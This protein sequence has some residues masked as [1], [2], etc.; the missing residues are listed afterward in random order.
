[1]IPLDI[2]NS[3]EQ[4]QFLTPTLGAVIAGVLALL[5]LIV[6]GFASGSEIAIFSLSPNDVSELEE[7]KSDADRK[8][9]EL[10]ED[11]ERTLATILITNN[12]VNVTIIML[13]NY[14]FAHVIDFGRAYWLQFLCI[15]ILLTFL[16]LLF[17]EIM[18]KMYSAHKPVDF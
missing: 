10:R 2:L 1:M 3:L 16:L 5:L 9:I 8:V 11:S 15:T 6:S 13:C 7:G 4:V 12:L 14:F 18:T 17:G